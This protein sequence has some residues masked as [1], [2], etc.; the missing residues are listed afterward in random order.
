MQLKQVTFLG[1]VHMEDYKSLSNGA[2]LKTMPSPDEVTMVMAQHIGR[3]AQPLVKKGDRVLVGQKIAE[4]QGFISAPVH[5]SVAGTV[6]GIIDYRT[7]AG[8]KVKAIVITNDHTEELGYESVDRTGE[9]LSPEEIIN[10]I[11]E[12]GIVGLG[13]A[14]FPTYVKLMPPKE[15]SLETVILNGAECEPYLTCDEWLMRHQS[16]KLVRGIHLVMKATGA[17]Q[18]FV[19]IEDNKPKA[20]EAMSQALASQDSIHLAVMKTKYPQG[21]ERRICDAVLGKQVAP[22]AL[23]SSVGAVIVNCAT[24]NAI[25]DA[26][27]YGKPLYERIVTVTGHAVR[28]PGNFVA[29]IGSRIKDLVDQ[30]GGYAEVPGKIVF[31]GPMMGVAQ[32]S[33]ELVT[34]KRNN[35]VL[36]MTRE[37]GKTRVISPCI[38]CGRCVEVCPAFLE[39]LYLATASKMEN[40]D[41]A[42]EYH[43]SQCIEC[44]SCTYICPANRPLMELIR[45]GKKQVA[46]KAKR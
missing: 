18:A 26:V 46:A 9:D 16:D 33:D 6:K 30:A 20:I 44:G 41:L 32:F 24:T 39:P 2:E 35:G 43:I 19:A 10:Y 1:G 27:D 38:R 45:F 25:V 12:A 13:G 23:P 31:G 40:F 15:G 22:G 36:V 17:K 4:A 28:Q 14:G 29:R 37:E 34:D 8:S 7:A 11:K 42:R 5:A 3:P 21:D